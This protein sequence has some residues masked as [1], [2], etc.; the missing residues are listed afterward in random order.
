MNKKKLI[1][2]ISSLLLIIAGVL[3]YNI[4]GKIYKPNVV[5]DGFI[6]IKTN[7]TL[8][9]VENEVRP[10]LKR[11]KPFIWV[12]KRK[13]Y[14]D[15][16]KPGKYKITKGFSN[17][18]L[19]NLLR[20][21]QQTPTTVV[22]NNQHSLEDLAGRV[23][24]QI[25]ADSIAILNAMKDVDFLSKHQFTTK[26]ALGMYVPN[27]YE[28]YWNTSAEQFRDR[29]FI[30]YNRF[31]DGKR[32]NQAKKLNL[33]RTKVMALASIVQK[34]TAKID[35]RPIVAGLYL[36]RLK[37]GWPLQADP[38]I[39]Y[40]LKEKFGE[41]FIVKRVLLK[42]LTIN[43]PYNTYQNK[44]IPPTLIAMPDISSIDAVLFS[45]KHNY[46]YMCASVDNI[47]F[48]EFANSLTQH[49]KNAIKYQRWMNQQG[50]NR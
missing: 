40:A 5:K 31:W 30:E 45:K 1:L 42:D 50:I 32:D 28:L 13:K 43:S 18:D 20:S 19:I 29:M 33:S 36:N 8:K 34:E 14:Q 21:G 9:D 6:Y 12:A 16:I 38:T 23:S 24:E 39:I 22:F 10:F 25:E 37:R 47:G 49:T 26:S 41:Y 15:A 46:Y 44:G 4:Y 11:V 2:L 48:H 3:V 7:S 35:E 17:N 27:S